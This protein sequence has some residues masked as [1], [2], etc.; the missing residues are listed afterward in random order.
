MAL[1]AR[2]QYET[3]MRRLQRVIKESGR[4]LREI[5]QMTV[6]LDPPERLHHSH[7]SLAMNGKQNRMISLRQAL[8]I[9]KVL[10]VPEIALFVD[11]EPEHLSKLDR[12][13][14]KAATLTATDLD[15]V[16]ATLGLQK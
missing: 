8:V 9:L 14:K 15:S 16:L 11:A 5:A 6:S 13:V 4:S 1:S 2:I 12:L 3:M 7:M 10:G